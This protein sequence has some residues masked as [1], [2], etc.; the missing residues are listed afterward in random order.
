MLPKLILKSLFM[1]KRSNI[2]WKGR[3]SNKV[4][5]TSV[6][7]LSAKTKWFKLMLT[8]SRPLQTVRE[9]SPMLSPRLDLNVEDRF[10][11]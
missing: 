6:V 10:G 2:T 9:T 8:M 5:L 3:T 11:F 4:V 7:S 1:K